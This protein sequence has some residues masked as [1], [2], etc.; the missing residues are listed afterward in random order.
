MN[1]TFPALAPFLLALFLLG[2]QEPAPTPTARVATIPPTSVSP[3][4]MAA[5]P[6]AVPI[7]TFAPT[8]IPRVAAQSA[9]PTPL[10]VPTAAPTLSPASTLTPTFTLT[11]EPTEKPAP[12]TPV[13]APIPTATAAPEPTPTA[14]LL[15]SPTATA[16]PTATPVAATTPTVAPAPR[17]TVRPT[18]APT[19]TPAVHEPNIPVMDR[20][21][22][23][24]WVVELPDDW[25]EIK[26]DWRPQGERLYG[27]SATSAQLLI[28]SQHLP[29]D[30]SLDQFAQLVE[31]NL[32][33][34]G[35]VR[36]ISANPVTLDGRPAHR[37]HYRLRLSPD[38]CHLEVTEIVTM[39]HILPGLS[40]GFRL[41]ALVCRGDTASLT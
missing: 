24:R 29:E 10:P 13:P 4:P 12:L 38:H 35:G 5:L 16:I 28:S 33:N 39:A 23:Y 18:L 41:K 37:I 31:D 34:D 26:E 1:R 7:P 8:E 6:T 25:I 22:E 2:C 19:H 40:G 15:P 3:T 17:A 27:S 32:S 14:T 30:Y 36:V 20:D 11:T 9:M 21:L